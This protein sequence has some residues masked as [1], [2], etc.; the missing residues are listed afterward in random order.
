MPVSEKRGDD[1]YN[2]DMF[3]P[4]TLPEKTDQPTVRKYTLK[5][6]QTQWTPDGHSRPVYLVNNQYP[7]PILQAYKGDTF[8]ITVEND[9]PVETSMHWHGMFQRGTSWFDGVPGASQCTI[10]PQSS[11]TYEFSTDGQVGTYWW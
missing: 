8:S 6:S 7:G 1:L 3:V 4:L 9:L 10:P 5:L 2:H 11:F